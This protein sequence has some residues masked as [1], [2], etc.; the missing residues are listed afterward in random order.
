MSFCIPPFFTTVRLTIECLIKQGDAEPEIM[1]FLLHT[2]FSQSKEPIYY[3]TRKA[4]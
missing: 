4:I 1:S 2:L 3:I